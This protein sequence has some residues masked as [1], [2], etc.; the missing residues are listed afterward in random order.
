M[1]KWW[2]CIHAFYWCFSF[3]LWVRACETPAN[4]NKQTKKQS[5][6]A[7]WYS[8]IT[9]TATRRKKLNKTKQRQIELFPWMAF[10]HSGYWLHNR[11]IKS[12]YVHFNANGNRRRR[13]R[14]KHHQQK[15]KQKKTTIHNTKQ[16]ELVEKLMAHFGS[17]SA[18][19]NKSFSICSLESFALQPLLSEVLICQRCL[20]C[21][22]SASL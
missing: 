10:S 4:R 12:H 19:F 1:L 9:E 18:A 22:H 13:R 15:Q 17:G 7:K 20:V 8:F 11:I 3:F 2:V 14:R 6:I 5:A 21:A 16:F